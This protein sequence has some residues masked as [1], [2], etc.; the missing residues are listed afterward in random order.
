M[1]MRVMNNSADQELRSPIISKQ[2][3]PEPYEQGDGFL[4]VN[5]R[6]GPYSHHRLDVATCGFAF[7]HRYVNKKSRLKPL[8]DRSV[9]SDR[10]SAA[11]EVL[12]QITN[13]YQKDRT[14]KLND[15][16]LAH[17][18]NLAVNKYPKAYPEAGGILE[19][20]QRYAHNPPPLSNEA[21]TE[22]WVAVKVE[23]GRLV[24]CLDYEEDKALMRGRIDIFDMSDDQTS[25]TI[26]DHKTQPNIETADTF[27][28]GIYA[29]MVKVCNPFIEEV[30]TVL[31]FARYDRYSQ[32]VVWDTKALQQIELEVMLRINI[33]ESR[34]EWH[35]TPYS[36]CQYCPFL[37]KCP[38]NEDVYS[39]D[40]QGRPQVD[41][42]TFRILG[43]TEKAVQL[44]QR[45]RV[46]R[47]SDKMITDELKEFAK[48]SG[49]GVATGDLLYD[50]HVGKPRPDWDRVNKDPALRAK[51]IA[52]L[53]K[54][55]E[56]PYRW[57]GFSATFTDKLWWTPNKALYNELKGLI[58][59]KQE[60]RFEGKKV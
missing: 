2:S 29:W 36:G 27:Q 60:T 17:W 56:D 16:T 55:R 12:E 52:S 24:E 28:M 41:Q 40:N 54:H 5:V 48:F 37:P 20:A 15:Q 46:F 6:Y 11:H 44:A 21:K 45:S 53:V 23:D 42:S 59:D 47:E 49:S 10:G 39:V 8:D 58:P 32:P 57:M 1:K 18:V 30:R 3:L 43:S 31:H 22:Q 13:S 35:A 7:Y 50:F 4:P 51:V 25:V 9:A 33:I 19:M 34:H 26:Y 38:V 14:Y